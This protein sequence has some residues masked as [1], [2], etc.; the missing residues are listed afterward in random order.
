MSAPNLS[1]SELSL[2]SYSI[3]EPYVSF[4]R[5]DLFSIIEEFILF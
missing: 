2:S 3:A 4:L 5:V 1:S